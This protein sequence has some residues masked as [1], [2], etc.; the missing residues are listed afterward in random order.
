MD[1]DHVFLWHIQNF[2]ACPHL[3]GQSFR[4]SSFV[5]GNVHATRWSAALFPRGVDQDYDG[6][7]SIDLLRDSEDAGPDRLNIGVEICIVAVDGT[8]VTSTGVYDVSRL[9]RG[10]KVPFEDLVKRKILL[11]DKGKH[12][13]GD[14]LTV[15]VKLWRID[16]PQLLTRTVAKTGVKLER[17]CFTWR[18]GNFGVC[19]EARKYVIGTSREPKLFEI[20]LESVGKK[21]DSNNKTYNIIIRQKADVKR[22][23]YMEGR[24]SVLDCRKRMVVFAEGSRT[25]PDH[26]IRHCWTF[27]SV[28][29]SEKL[30]KANAVQEGV[31][32]LHFD[33]LI[34]DGT[35]ESATLEKSVLPKDDNHPVTSL[36]D[37]V[38]SL[39]ESKDFADV[40]LRVSTG[41]T[42]LAHKWILSSRSP[43]FHNKFQEMDSIEEGGYFEVFDH[44]KLP[45]CKVLDMEPS[46][47]KRLLKFVYTD[48]LDVECMG[49]DR[50]S[51]LFIAAYKYKIPQL[52]MLCSGFM[53]S[54]LT[55]SNF[56]RA[57]ILAEATDDEQLKDFALDYV[58]QHSEDIML[59]DDWQAFVEGAPTLAS[60][61]MGHLRM[62][63]VQA[64]NELDC[65]DSIT[66][67]DSEEDDSSDSEED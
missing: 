39:Y 57:I 5:A 19:R 48:T 44:G 53:R 50:A 3:P 24:I 31:L 6:F 9:A 18:V 16:R 65:E 8:D 55:Y 60:K 21:E 59:R 4:S 20:F 47:L 35:L 51:C 7:V 63:A 62:K 42:F 66:E 17:K 25:F 12:L 34:F 33:L 10:E 58:A 11:A 27:P 36:V 2:S 49:F 43:V 23:V 29:N 14:T 32:R 13:P 61:V 26:C 40:V 38:K 30:E 56:Y 15:K 64:A 28:I 22:L 52:R 54:K 46:T 37:H 45:V 67:D 1:H 41:H